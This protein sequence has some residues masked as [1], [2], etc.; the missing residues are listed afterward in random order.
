MV[1]YSAILV[2]F[3]GSFHCAGMCGPI[4]LALPAQHPSRLVNMFR[5]LTYNFG[6]VLT[7]SILGLIVGLIGHRIAMAGFQQ[8]LSIFSGVLI[9]AI[10]LVSFFNPTFLFN[11][12]FVSGYVNSIKSAFKKLFATKSVYTLFLIGVVNGLL[13]CGFVYIAL[14][15]AIATG[16]FL[17]SA[18]YMALFG[19]GTIPMMLSFSVAGNLFGAKFYKFFRKATPYIAVLV[20]ALLIY[21][22]MVISSPDCCHPGPGL[23]H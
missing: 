16:N 23:R 18:G 13:P 5:V 11:H 15:A 22:G 19:L 6:R 3:L 14:A 20:G 2:G 7:Y 9:I 12:S 4:A 8:G 1:L 17:N 10:A 21:R